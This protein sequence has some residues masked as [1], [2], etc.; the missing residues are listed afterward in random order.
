MNL[1]LRR[2]FKRLH[3]DVWGLGIGLGISTRF[4][5]LSFF[6]LLLHLGPIVLNVYLCPNWRAQE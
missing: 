2:R 5:G 4:N 1:W 6:I 3:S